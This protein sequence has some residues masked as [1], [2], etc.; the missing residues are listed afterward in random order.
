MFDF[1]FSS[2]TVMTNTGV[3]VAAGAAASFFSVAAMVRKEA[4]YL[5]IQASFLL[6][7]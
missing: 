5:S 4:P 7:A 1:G 6:E 3:L 2:C